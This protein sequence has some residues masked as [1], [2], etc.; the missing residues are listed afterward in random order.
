LT[1]IYD[2]IYQLAEPYW[3]TR[4]GEIHMPLAYKYARQ[5]LAHYPEADEAIVLPAILLH[6]VG[7]K[8][9]PEDL[10]MQALVGS[11]N[12]DN[13]A[14]VARQHEIEGARIAGEI[15][16]SLNYEEDKIAEIQHI[17]DGHDTRREALSL[18]DTLVKDADKLWRF[19][20]VGTP[21]C[22][23]WNDLAIG[24]YLDFVESRIESWLFT[25][26]ARELALA[27]LAQSR[28]QLAGGSQTIY[29][30]IYEAAERYWA[31]R[32]NEVHMPMAYDFA[33]KLL[34]YYPQADEA[35]VLP[36]I[37]LHD[38]GWK[39]VPEEKQLNAFGPKATDKAANRLHE[40][41][42]VRLA[43]EILASFNY[44]L[45]K[46][47][48]ILNIIDGH[49][50]RLEALSLNDK[51]VKD[52]DKLWR[53]TPTGVGIDHRRF[54]IELET[55]LDYLS[56]KIE[57]WL[58]TPEAKTMARAELARAKMEIRD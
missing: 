57:E 1:T 25:D 49:D 14:D 10:Q 17:I 46:T 6:D 38:I 47:R 16:T 29:A 39:M 21:I 12:R 35:V 40:V 51:L 36:A 7:Y 23:Q 50:S 18:N 42:G 24:P 43:S 11:P 44:D 26:K 58:F 52:A 9:I 3:Q 53:F 56:S 31:T 54:G 19:D 41:E 4:Q 32:Q 5:L 8:L 28:A 37:L 34:A 55:Y 48:E 22:A 33:K 20:P 15:L 27:L 45:A 30:K 2:Q 13:R